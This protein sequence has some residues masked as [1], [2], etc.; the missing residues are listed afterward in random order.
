MK[1]VKLIILLLMIS[2]VLVAQITGLS[3]WDIWIDAGHSQNE[4]MGAYNYS[5]AMKNL[6]VALHLQELLLNRTD[7]DTVGMTRTNDQVSVGLSERCYM[8]NNFGASWFHS[9]HSNAPSTSSNATL[10]LWGEL[11][12]GQP[13]PPIGG[14][15][16][17]GYMVDLLTRGMR[18]TTEGSIGD[19]SFY[20]WSDWCQTSGGPYL[21]VNRL[22]DMPSELSEAGYHT[23]PTANM[24]NMNWEYKRLEAWTF[25]WS[26]LQFHDIPRPF[27][28]IATGRI[29]D[30]E[31]GQFINGA[32]V[33]FNGD[34]YTTDTWNSLFYQ[35]S[36][37]PDLLR[38][39]FYY[40]EDLPDSTMEMIVSAD[41]Y[42]PD[43][44]MVTVLDTFITFTDFDLLSSLP[45]YVTT[46]TPVD[47]DTSYPTINDIEINFSR[48]VD[49]ISVEAAW[50]LTPASPGS[51]RWTNNGKRVIFS[52]DLLDY[53]TDYTLVISDSAH[54]IHGHY[55]D[56]DHDGVAGGDFVLTFHSS[57]ED[58]YP[59]LVESIYP[60]A[61][62]NSVELHPIINIMFDDVV[63]PDTNT[64]NHVYLERYEDHT[65]PSVDIEHFVFDSRSV[66]NIF[67]DQPLHGDEVYVTRIS[68]GFT[69]TDGNQIDQY[70]SYSFSTS[71]R[72]FLI[73]G[74]DNFESG[75]SDNWAHAGFSGSNVGN[76]PDSI[77]RAINTD[78]L[79][80]ITGSTKSME[81][82]YG[83][84]DS[85]DN[86]LLRIYLQGGPPRA[87]RFDDTYMMQVYVFGD[88]SNNQFRFAVD[89]NNVTGAASDHEVSPWFT[90]DWFG[91][92]LVS[93]DMS[94]GTTGTWLGDG[95]LDG[96]MRFDS[97]QLTHQV[98]TPAFGSLIFD[99]LRL[100][101]MGPV[102]VD[103]EIT[104]QPNEYQLTQ[105]Y[106]NPFNPST[107]ISYYLPL[108][109]QISL[110][111]YD[112]SGRLVAT[113]E[114]QHQSAGMH[115]T[116]WDGRNDQGITQSSGSYIYRLD[117][118]GGS[119][120][121][122]MT[123]VK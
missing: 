76:V 94:S 83:W 43:T 74:I 39:G 48:E 35:Y 103:E 15:E 123:L 116:V 17:S 92:R 68:P 106:P 95:S 30:M 7:I 5:E 50:S 64:A 117:Y 53:E 73:T 19:C 42:Y 49:Q 58:I 63:G 27:V 57:P 84:Y 122:R 71:N 33:S 44:T 54:D 77:K 102:R 109:C 2:K 115:T 104:D 90:V 38:N 37:D 36:S 86:W 16:M 75:L 97:I 46:T 8:A 11:Y 13:D 61:S 59:P 108:S 82:S 25:L 119:I 26:I 69:D 89:D 6:G 56:G 14:E 114:R 62:S 70:Y 81:I 34:T 98:G 3:G 118:P 105:N 28:G 96:Q 79:N 107:T 23:N 111:V 87:V 88:G 113:L 20:T 78:I 12:N 93:W 32:N 85:S 100:V 80:Q 60:A 1:S 29:K 55:L 47:G 24:L 45:P 67:P 21:A 52:P 10:L 66:L 31:S 101:Q 121:R 41:N 22:T 51:F 4:N 65:Y 120:S 40:F 72:D 9:L 18:T 110:L 91:W 99:D 112:I